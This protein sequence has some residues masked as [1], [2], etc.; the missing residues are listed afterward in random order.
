MAKSVKKSE[1][2]KKITQKRKKSA[3]NAKK[4]AGKAKKITEFVDSL[5]ELHKWQGTLLR[6]LKSQV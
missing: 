2:K 4:T 6:K 3:G 5:L 1:K